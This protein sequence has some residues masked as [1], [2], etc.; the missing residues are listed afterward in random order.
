M[1]FVVQSLE[2]IVGSFPLC[3]LGGEKSLIYQLENFRHSLGRETRVPKTQKRVRE[4]TSL[5][6]PILLFPGCL[7]KKFNRSSTLHCRTGENNIG[8]N[9]RGYRRT[10]NEGSGILLLLAHRHWFDTE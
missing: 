2:Q 8:R 5:C 1:E 6:S 9:L 3:R 10:C 4:S 7:K